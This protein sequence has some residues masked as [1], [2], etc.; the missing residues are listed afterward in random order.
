M[1]IGYSISIQHTPVI[2]K[3]TCLYIYLHE[4][5]MENSYQN[6]NTTLGEVLN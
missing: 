1:Y 2:Y 3:L 5:E 6:V 4:W